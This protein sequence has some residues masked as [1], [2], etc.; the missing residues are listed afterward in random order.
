ML[1]FIVD[2]S[3]FWSI[4]QGL[5]GYLMPGDERN[6]VLQPIF[7]NNHQMSFEKR[8]RNLDIFK[9]VPADCSQPTDLGGVISILT[10]ILISY[11][12]IV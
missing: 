5:S 8:L 9:K 4:F 11:F 6:E 10:V 12:T 7:N 1:N 2:F 3:D